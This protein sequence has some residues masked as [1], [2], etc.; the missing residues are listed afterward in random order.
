MSQY[1]YNNYFNKPREDLSPE[2][3]VDR[4]LKKYES[5]AS[6]SQ[7]ERY[8]KRVPL[9]Y[10]DWLKDGANIPFHQEVEHEPMIE[11]YIPK[12]RFQDLVE[13]EKIIRRIEEENCDLKYM[14]EQQEN[15][16]RIRNENPAVKKA[17][18]NYQLLLNLCRSK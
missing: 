11:V 8:Y 4:F 18:D 9:S 13:R 17:W 5:R 3:E 1:Y 10:T 16:N 6:I 12:H 14:V 15:D 7:R 2:A